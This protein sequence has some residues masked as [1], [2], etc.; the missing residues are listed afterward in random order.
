VKVSVNKTKTLMGEKIPWWWI[1]QED[2]R[3][4]VD[5]NSIKYSV[6]CSKCLRLVHTNTGHAK[7]IPVRQACYLSDTNVCLKSLKRVY[8]R[9]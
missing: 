6:Q 9:N 1:I 4:I 2:V 7:G 3:R 5:R 8:Y